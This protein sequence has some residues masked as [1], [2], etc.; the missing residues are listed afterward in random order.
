MRHRC[1]DVSVLQYL[2]LQ[3]LDPMP[4]PQWEPTPGGDWNTPTPWPTEATVDMAYG[5][6]SLFLWG[7]RKYWSHRKDWLVEAPV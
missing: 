6:S 7:Y 2:Q 4:D 3:P 1:R 5:L